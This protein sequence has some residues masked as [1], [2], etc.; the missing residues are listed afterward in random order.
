[1]SDGVVVE[2]TEVLMPHF[3]SSSRTEEDLAGASKPD[4]SDLWKPGSA[5]RTHGSPSISPTLHSVFT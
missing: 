2:L 4:S 5:I 1:M 3:I